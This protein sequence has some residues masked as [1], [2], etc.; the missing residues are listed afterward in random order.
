M[1]SSRT[2]SR[3]KVW[4]FNKVSGMDSVPETLE[5]FHTLTRLS[6]REV[7]IEFC[8]RESFDQDLQLQIAVQIKYVLSES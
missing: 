6:V 1:K 2:D 7:F 4:N 5:K 8:R 3:V